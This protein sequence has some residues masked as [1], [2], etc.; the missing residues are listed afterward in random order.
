MRKKGKEIIRP[1]GVE[2]REYLNDGWGICNNCGALMD[3]EIRD[4]IGVFTCPACGRECDVMD[5]EYE[6]E[7]TME[8]VQDERGDEYLIPRDDMPPAGCRACGG[9]YPY[10]KASCKMYDD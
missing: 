6:E 4:R 3:E 1:V 9:P 8:L 2:I 5:Y 7:D 10:C